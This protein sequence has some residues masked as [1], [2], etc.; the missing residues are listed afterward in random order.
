MREDKMDSKGI[1]TMRRKSKRVIMNKKQ[2][3]YQ[4]F[5]Q[6]CPIWSGVFIS[7]R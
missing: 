7:Q 3:K 2:I 5:L 6:M 1:K 4:T